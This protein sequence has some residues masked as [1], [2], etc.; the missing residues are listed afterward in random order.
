VALAAPALAATD[1][2]VLVSRVTGPAGAQADGDSERSSISAN[3]VVQSE[4][5]NLSAE[6]V[7]GVTNVF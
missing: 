4:A 7:N 5:D 1:D 2:L 6:D 3:G